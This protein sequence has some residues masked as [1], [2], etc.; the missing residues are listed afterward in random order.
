MTTKTAPEISNDRQEIS[1]K[2]AGRLELRSAD[3]TNKTFRFAFPTDADYSRFRSE[4]VKYPDVR[5]ER[6]VVGK[7]GTTWCAVKAWAGLGAE[8]QSISARNGGTRLTDG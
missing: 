1:A 5:P 2:L 4:V 7:I 8:I 3:A 6:E